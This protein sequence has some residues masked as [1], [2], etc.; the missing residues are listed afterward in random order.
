MILLWGPF[1]PKGTNV[2]V[3]KTSWQG[4][5][6]RLLCGNWQGRVEVEGSLSDGKDAD[7]HDCSGVPHTHS[8]GCR[9]EPPLLW[10]TSISISQWGYLW[11]PLFILLRHSW[12]C[13]P[14]IRVRKKI[15]KLKVRHFGLAA[16]FIVLIQDNGKKAGLGVKWWQFC[17]NPKLELRTKRKM[18]EKNWLI[19][20][21][22]IPTLLL[23]LLSLHEPSTTYYESSPI[24]WYTSIILVPTLKLRAME[25]KWAISKWGESLVYLPTNENFLTFWKQSSKDLLENR[26]HFILVDLSNFFCFYKS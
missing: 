8:L 2:K 26:I 23:G 3:L 9:I 7:L 20:I 16:V 1:Y 24:L 25:A 5:Q 13:F 15:C 12:D 11:R 21:S 17:L 22:F 18:K 4:C 6:K 10:Q 14:K 19:F